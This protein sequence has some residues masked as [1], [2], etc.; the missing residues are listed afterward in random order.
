[1]RGVRAQ[2]PSLWRLIRLCVF[3]CIA[4]ACGAVN[5]SAQEQYPKPLIHTPHDHPAE[6]VLLFD[7][8]GLHALD[9]ANWVVQHPHSALAEL[10]ARG[11]TY[12]NARTVWAD[13][14]AGLMS[15]ATGGTPISTGIV[16]S[17]GYDR[18]L[19]PPG[20]RCAMKGAV[21]DLDAMLEAD[22]KVTL[23]AAPL[24]PL[25]G[26]RQLSPHDLLRVN[27]IFEVVHES[28]GRV[29]WAGSNAAL[30]DLLRGPSGR[31]LDEA[32]GFDSSL[33]PG[34]AESLL[35]D[36]RRVNAVL[37]WIGSRTCDGSQTAPVPM[38]SGMSFTSLRIAQANGSGYLDASGRPSVVVLA[39]LA[40]IDAEIGSILRDL[41]REKLYDTTWILVTS[42]FG[43]CPMDARN[44][45][46]VPLARVA[47][48]ADSVQQGAIAHLNGGYG[49]MIWLTDQERTEQI[50]GAFAKR[51]DALGIQAI[52]YGVRLGLTL[53]SPTLDSRT[54]DIVLEPN[55]EVLWGE[56][57][58]SFAGTDDA[59]THVALLVS[60]AQ[61][62]LEAQPGGRVD[63][64]PVPTTQVPALLLRALGM[65]KFRLNALHEE[66][67]PALPGIF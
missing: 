42:S 41:R 4:F 54:P 38:L 67:S 53:N 37:N 11:V 39:D 58:G 66:H 31:G 64:T 16:S 55:D 62:A 47:A 14:A 21:L 7:V 56:A 36:Q 49:A 35:G 17:D 32:C 13:P 50:A 10:S 1:M 57:S 46:I 8:Q 29:A 23:L 33:H 12:T 63:K 19:S 40:T 3:L 22:G 60:G 59:A 26:C 48:V 51:S 44:R 61:L 6:R 15:I 34:E 28:G 43:G 20:S 2:A 27:T 25:H 9:L 65:E 52:D 24:D 45:R 18:A 5:I 30:T